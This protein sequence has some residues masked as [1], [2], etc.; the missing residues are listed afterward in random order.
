MIRNFALGMTLLGM[1]IA[2]AKAASGNAELG[3]AIYESQ[4]TSCHS[5]DFNGVGPAHRGVFGRPIG[6]AKDYE[7]SPALKA[8]NGRWTS[9][10]LDKWLTDPESFIPGERM[11][12]RLERPEDRA[13]VI[14]YLKTLTDRE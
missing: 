12:F 9:E 7:Y 10:N 2:A 4:C 1:L 13:N 6:R 14:E 5:V 11:G 3:R 8:A